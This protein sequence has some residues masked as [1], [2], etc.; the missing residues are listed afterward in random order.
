MHRK[1]YLLGYLRKLGLGTMLC[2]D[3]I[4]DKNKTTT[5]NDKER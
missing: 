4:E 2:A 1:S 5:H 3:I